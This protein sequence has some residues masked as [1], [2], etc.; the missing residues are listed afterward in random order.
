MSNKCCGKNSKRTGDILKLKEFLKIISDA[1]RL[2][3]L[4]LLTRK[5]LCVCEIFEELEL[6]QN[7]VSHHLAKLEKLSLVKKRKEGTFV[8][9]SVNQKTLKQYKNLFNQVIK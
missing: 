9:Y 5:E 3:I 8:I 1:N 7:L 6:P 4:C 2:R